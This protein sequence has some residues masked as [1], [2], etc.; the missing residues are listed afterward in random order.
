MSAHMSHRSLISHRLA[1][2]KGPTGFTSPLDHASCGIFWS[3]PLWQIWLKLSKRWQ[4]ESGRMADWH[5]HTQQS[6]DPHC[7][8]RKQDVPEG[9]W[10]RKSCLN[11]SPT[12]LNSAFLISMLLTKPHESLAS[13]TFPLKVPSHL[14]AFHPSHLC[15]Y[16]ILRCVKNC[17]PTDEEAPLLSKWSPQGEQGENCLVPQTTLVGTWGDEFHPF[18]GCC[19]NPH[20]LPNQ[21]CSHQF[22]I[23]ASL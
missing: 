12:L 2:P 13:T 15:L 14:G 6:I 5:P 17:I 4:L 18:K 21:C 7:R 20:S 23:I 8:L 19:F 22:H 9:I 3:L 16:P 11:I 10:K 1:E